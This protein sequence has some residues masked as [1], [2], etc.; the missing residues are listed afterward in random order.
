MQMS[1]N[2]YLTIGVIVYWLYL[3]GCICV[4]QYACNHFNYNTTQS[5]DIYIFHEDIQLF[6]SDQ[7]YNVSITLM[8]KNVSVMRNDIELMNNSY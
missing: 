1:Q 3:H 6:V 8:H 2:D 4:Y 5:L 7:S